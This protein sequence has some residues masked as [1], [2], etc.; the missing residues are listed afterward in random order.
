MVVGENG[1]VAL[2]VVAHVDEGLRRVGGQL[3]VIE[4]RRRT[5]PLLV[6]RHV[7][8]GAAVG[9]A[10]RVGTA[11]GDPREQRL[12][13]QRAV[14]RGLGVETVSGYSAHQRIRSPR[15]DMTT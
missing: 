5:R 9:V 4:E 11:L 13:C 14:D 3:D 6:N 7:R 15:S 2:G 12:G 10:D 1:G 8:A